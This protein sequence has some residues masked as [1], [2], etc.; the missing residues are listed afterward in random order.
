MTKLQEA[1]TA[2]RD[3]GHGHAAAI[4]RLAIRLGVDPGTV[5]RTLG[6]SRTRTLR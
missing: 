3:A 4:D 2:L 1:Y 6:R 5:K